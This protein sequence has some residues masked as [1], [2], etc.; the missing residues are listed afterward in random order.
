MIGSLDDRDV[1]DYI[2]AEIFV[3]DNIEDLII[4]EILLI[5]SNFVPHIPC[6]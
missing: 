4:L 6:I 1:T 5:F 2:S 3:N